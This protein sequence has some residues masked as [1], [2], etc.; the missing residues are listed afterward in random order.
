M[1]VTVTTRSPVST[2][3]SVS[4]A[5]MKQS[6]LLKQQLCR[7]PHIDAVV[8]ASPAT[9]ADWDEMQ[10][11]PKCCGTACGCFQ[12]ASVQ[13]PADG[14]G[15]GL[16]LIG[17]LHVYMRLHA[18][19]A[20]LSA[21]SISPT[22]DQ[23]RDDAYEYHVS[24]LARFG[25]VQSL[26]LASRLETLRHAMNGVHSQND[27]RT[28]HLVVLSLLGDCAV[29]LVS[30]IER[31][32][33]TEIPGVPP[34]QAPRLPPSP[35]A[36]ASPA[37]QSRGDASVRFQ[38]TP[39]YDTTP[40]YNSMH[41]AAT[42]AAPM[43]LA[44]KVL[45]LQ[46]HLALSGNYQEVLNQAAEDL[47]INTKGMAMAEI[48]TACMQEMFGGAGV[49][50]DAAIPQAASSTVVPIAP[51][52][53]PPP[54]VS[55]PMAVTVPLALPAVGAMAPSIEEPPPLSAL[56]SIEEPPPSAPGSSIDS[57]TERVDGT[58]AQKVGD[59]SAPSKADTKM[60]AKM[61]AL[62]DDV[63]APTWSAFLQLLHASRGEF[64]G[65]L[66]GTLQL[67]S[68]TPHARTLVSGLA[69]MAKAPGLAPF[70]RPMH[71]QSKACALFGRCAKRIASALDTS[72]DPV[73]TSKYAAELR[74]IKVKI[75]QT[76]LKKVSGAEK[77][78][79]AHVVR[80]F[81]NLTAGVLPYNRQKALNR[82]LQRH[83]ATAA[84]LWRFGTA[85][86]AEYDCLQGGDPSDGDHVV[87]VRAS[88]TL[89]SVEI[90]SGSKFAAVT[91]ESHRKQQQ[92]VTDSISCDNACLSNLLA[93]HARRSSHV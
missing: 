1:Q 87:H 20:Q 78:G 45:L 83:S 58:K 80:G 47:N 56:D 39:V 48:A 4:K 36:V 89:P 13:L 50:G 69:A 3:R 34:S 63:T 22:I 15:G 68:G 5:L 31:P 40:L 51:L 93:F 53:T 79:L 43:T 8:V 90:L 60:L 17:K 57:A 28:V 81:D 2:E 25:V 32:Q 46:S 77:G 49:E 29:E 73:Q 42:A 82:A 35:L 30:A 27:E 75:G 52:A 64:F 24:E 41:P 86:V 11:T 38:E 76:T 18:P 23:N 84:V 33:P 66:S 65:T 19:A 6:R 62:I 59:A 54:N 21:M 61:V 88:A 55:V 91:G 85:G 7:I 16:F 37:A 74:A 92:G 67:L 71:R 14:E 70:M 9:G 10:V 72:I 44:E 26:P 12:S